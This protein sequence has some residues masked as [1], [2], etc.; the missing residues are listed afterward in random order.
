VAWSEGDKEVADAVA[1]R[2]LGVGG[3]AVAADERVVIE[4]AED[5]WWRIDRE[6]ALNEW[7]GKEAA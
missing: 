7:F 5:W 3:L 6:A 4:P 2:E 1:A